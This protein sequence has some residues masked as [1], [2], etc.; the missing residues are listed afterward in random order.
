[1]SAEETVPRLAQLKRSELYSEQLG[2]DLATRADGEYFK[3]FLASLLFGSRISE[4]VARQ[5]YQAFEAH[6]LLTPRRILKAGWDY[7]VCPVMREGGYVRYDE[8]KSAQVMRDCELLMAE[9]G[10]SL[11]K[12]HELARDGS[13]L[14]KRLLDFY[15]VGPVT[16]NIFLRELRPYWRKADPVPLPAVVDAARRLRLDLGQFNRKTVTFTRIE[17]GLI[18]LRK[19]LG[20]RS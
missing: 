15:G 11:S 1:M 6:R 14:E 2:I 19:Q 12:L 7:L 8:S 9:Y 3:W 20:L 4:T 18:R 10:G 5:T 13:D 17:A 16:A